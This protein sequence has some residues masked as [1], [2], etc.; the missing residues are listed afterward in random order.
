MTF[1]FFI[2]CKMTHL[3]GSF[4]LYQHIWKGKRL[5]TS[6]WSTKTAAHSHSTAHCQD[7]CITVWILLIQRGRGRGGGGGGRG[8][9][10]RDS[11]EKK[12]TSLPVDTQIQTVPDAC[13]INSKTDS[14]MDSKY[15]ELEGG[16]RVQYQPTTYS[17][18]PIPR[19]ISFVSKWKIDL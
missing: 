14:D 15:E 17:Q 18:Y 11:R 4:K 8:R 7:V 6:E 16:L 10:D 12:N 2:S 1:V 9:Q 13:Y 19:S 3:S 5:R